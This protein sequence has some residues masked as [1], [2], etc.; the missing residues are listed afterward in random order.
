MVPRSSPLPFPSISVFCIYS[1]TPLSSVHTATPSDEP[2]EDDHDD[3]T[4]EASKLLF[5]YSPDELVKERRARLMG[6]VM[7]LADFAR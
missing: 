7:G 2:A 5:F 3:A 6:T 4:L 1:T